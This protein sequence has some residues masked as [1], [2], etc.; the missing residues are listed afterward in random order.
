MIA[1]WPF[2]ALKL[3]G[4]GLAV[5]AMLWALAG[6]RRL[7]PL[8]PLFW[9][10]MSLVG[11][12]WIS[13]LNIEGSAAIGPAVRLA[14]TYLGYGVTYWILSTMSISPQVVKRVVGVMLISGLVIALIGIVQYRFPFVWVVSFVTLYS[15]YAETGDLTDAQ[16]WDGVFRVESITGNPDTLGL[17]MQVLLPFAFMW[18]MRR[19]SAGGVVAGSAL[20]LALGLALLLSLTR[21]V[22]V[23][24]ALVVAPLL[25]YKLGWRR[26]LPWLVLGLAFAVATVLVWEPLRTRSVS[27]VT[28]WAGGDSSTAGG[29]RRDALVI[30][31]HMFR[32]NFVTGVGLTQQLQLW[33]EYAALEYAYMVALPIHNDFLLLGIEL[34]VLGPLLLILLLVTAWR[35]ARGV[36]RHF[37]ARGQT[38]LLDLANAAEIVLVAMA[39][40]MMLYPIVHNNRYFFLLLAIIG[41]LHR[42]ALDQRE[43]PPASRVAG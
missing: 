2:Q 29:W 17:A 3:A 40:N 8:D 13:L 11:L 30:A 35:T 37:A 9:V 23:T 36:Q 16:R 32:D 7:V 18:L 25:A 41:A 26:T 39:V 33:G 4:A 14:L 27:I 43:A 34:G 1:E 31:L 22:F 15:A 28:E 24:T 21:G 19:R 42:V 38:D 6:R 20:L 12:V 10:L 5:S